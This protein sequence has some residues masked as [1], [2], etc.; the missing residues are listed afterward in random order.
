M[1]FRR[2]RPFKEGR[3]FCHG[4]HSIRQIHLD[5]SS[6]LQNCIRLTHHKIYICKGTQ[7]L[8]GQIRLKIKFGK[9]YSFI[10]IN[11]FDLPQFQ[12]SRILNVKKELD[13][14]FSTFRTWFIT[15]VKILIAAKMSIRGQRLNLISFF[16]TG[17]PQ[18]DI[19]DLKNSVVCK[20]KDIFK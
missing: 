18:C 15:L 19:R 6:D 4:S 5:R 10:F 16:I 7:T 2:R 1:V 8:M 20:N 12:V 3:Y 14:L 13:Y 11:Y 17:R 9:V